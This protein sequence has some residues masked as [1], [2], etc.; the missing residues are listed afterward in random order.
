MSGPLPDQALTLSM[1]T[2]RILLFDAGNANNCTDVMVSTVYR[3]DR[4]EQHQ[5]I[6]AICLH[7]PSS[8]VHLKAGRIQHAT[9]DLDLG[10][11]PCEPEAI[12]SCLIADDDP[13]H[14]ASRGAEAGDQSIKVT[15][16]QTIDAG[17]LSVRAR[18]RE[19]PALLAQ[20]DGGV[21]C[22]LN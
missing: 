17:L 14:R 5:R 2:T 22:F 4:S 11:S 7:A 1:R 10:Q 16:R 15:A 21:E 6:D 13:R 9:F 3:D 8:A 12:I 20:L 18:D 19:K